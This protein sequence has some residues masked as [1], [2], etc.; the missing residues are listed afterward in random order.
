MMHLDR[1]ALDGLFKD[2]G[3]VPGL[4]AL[5]QGVSWE[6]APALAGVGEVPIP[7]VID[8]TAGP[9]AAAAASAEEE[10]FSAEED[11]GG[12]ELMVIEGA[13]GAV[14]SVAPPPAPPALPVEPR[15]AV[16]VEHPPQR[17]V[18]VVAPA[19]SGAETEDTLLI[20]RRRRWPLMAG[21]G[22][23]LAGAAV[24]LALPVV[25]R[26][27][28]AAATETAT[29]ETHSK[30]APVASASPVSIPEPAPSEASAVPQ[31]TPRAQADSRSHASR[32]QDAGEARGERGPEGLSGSMRVNGGLE[33]AMHEMR[34]PGVFDRNSSHPHDIDAAA[35]GETVRLLRTRCADGTIVVTGHTCVLGDARSN[36][37]LSLLRARRVGELLIRAGF[38]PERM[39]FVGRGDR[40]PIADNRVIEGMRQNRRVMVSCDPNPQG[41]L[42]PAGAGPGP[43]Q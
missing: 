10:Q 16:Q 26:G 39:R 30:G 42:G 17:S 21:A 23:V 11:T 38:S 22:M 13:A 12:Y 20:R 4:A 15:A 43:G 27:H 24:L 35:L 5:P 31:V 41:H 19:S 1:N 36:R 37:E 2:A 29:Q 28:P 7:I 6:G 34:F 32:G 3:L 40:Q 8:G 9:S 33:E 25:R 14:S 18:E